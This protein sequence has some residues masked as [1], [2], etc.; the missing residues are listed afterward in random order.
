MTP[1]AADIFDL[2][3]RSWPPEA[4]RRDG[5]WV[6]RQDSSGSKRTMAAS[7][8]PG[9]N[10]DTAPAEIEQ[11]EVAMTALDQPMLFQIRGPSGP[12]DQALGERGYRIVDPCTIYA[13]RAEAL[14]A[15]VPHATAWSLWE[16]LAIQKEI[17]AE[18]GIGPGR[19]AIMERA[20][21]PKTSIIGRVNDRAAGAAF[22]SGAGSLA[23]IHGVET[24]ADYRRKGVARWMMVAACNWCIE[25]GIDW[26]TLITVNDNLA[27]N[28]LYTSIGMTPVGQYHYRIRD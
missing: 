19:L 22:V 1:H 18:G 13:I 5:I 11:A 6:I 25:N 23:M 16:P 3:D 27:A 8:A 7:L 21:A 4:M 24:L 12:L 9:A 28:A 15:P 26:L 10:E 20:G 2:I 17:W 14:A